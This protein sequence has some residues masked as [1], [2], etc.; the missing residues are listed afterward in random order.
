MQM[1]LKSI[2]L[3]PKDYFRITMKQTL[4]TRCLT[5]SA[6]STARAEAVLSA[7]TRA[8]QEPRPATI[9]GLASR[10]AAQTLCVQVGNFIRAAA[11]VALKQK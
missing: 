8:Q 10:C 5:K 3:F 7:Q 2:N 9:A 11:G 6:Q 1:D 4:R